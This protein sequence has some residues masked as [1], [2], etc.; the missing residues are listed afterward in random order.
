[1]VGIS[2]S[3]GISILWLYIWPNFKYHAI[4]WMGGRINLW[5][6]SQWY[7]P[8]KWFNQVGSFV[9]YVQKHTKSTSHD[10]WSSLRKEKHDC[11]AS[12]LMRLFGGSTENLPRDHGFAHFSPSRSIISLR[13]PTPRNG[14][15]KTSPG[16]EEGFK[17]VRW[18]SCDGPNPPS[19][20]STSEIVQNVWAKSW[21]MVN[22]CKFNIQ[23]VAQAIFVCWCSWQLTFNP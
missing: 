21:K 16:S 5:P 15:S 9:R 4:L 14:L 2:L 23:K 13:D 8:E 20:M 18:T 22:A 17:T 10:Q 1:M 11:I 3:E 19:A 12:H 6:N 7:P